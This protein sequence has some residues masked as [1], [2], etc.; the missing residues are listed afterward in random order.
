M[1][2]VEIAITSGSCYSWRRVTLLLSAEVIVGSNARSL[3]VVQPPADVVS[4]VGW[5]CIMLV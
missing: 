3:L 5:Q 4:C 2:H 1:K